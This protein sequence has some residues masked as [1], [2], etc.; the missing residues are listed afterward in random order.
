[1]QQ[2]PVA[3]G[4]VGVALLTLF[5]TSI[6]V[7]GCLACLGI[8]GLSPWWSLAF[9]S[10]LQDYAAMA[11]TSSIKVMHKLFTTFEFGTLRYLRCGGCIDLCLL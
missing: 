8:G 10:V 9:L 4:I 1:M 3:V 2:V 5:V 7:L 6:Q 11:M